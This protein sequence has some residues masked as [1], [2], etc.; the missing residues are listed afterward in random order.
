MSK[1]IKFYSCDCGE[2]VYEDDR[3]CV[4]CGKKTDKR[5]FRKEELF[6]VIEE[7]NVHEIHLSLTPT[8]NVRGE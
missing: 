4:C 8:D 5:R 2:D 1:T 3:E 7:K 6:T